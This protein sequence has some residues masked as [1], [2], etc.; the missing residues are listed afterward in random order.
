MRARTSWRDILACGNKTGT[1]PRSGVV[2]RHFVTSLLVSGLAV[3]TVL[4]V[5]SAAA[6]AD[7]MASRRLQ[8]SQMTPAEQQE[9]LRKQEQFAALPLEEQDRLRAL[10]AAI[11]TDAHADRLRQ[12]LKNYHEWLKTL[13]PAERAELAELAPEDRV[14]RI[15]QLQQRQRVARQEAQLAEVLSVKDMQAIIRWTENILWEHRDKVLEQLPPEWRKRLEKEDQQKQRRQLLLAASF[16]SRRSGLHPLAL[17]KPADIE[18][19]TARLSDPAKQE[20][21]KATDLAEQRKVVRGWIGASM[22]RLEPWQGRRKLPPPADQEL[23]DFFQNELRPPQRDRLLK[24]PNEQMRE[25]LRRMY[26][27]HERW[28]SPGRGF[29]KGPRPKGPRDRLGAEQPPKNVPV[30]KS[31]P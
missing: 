15:K 14:K 11:D 25:E 16:S 2:A 13:S 21:A 4:S 26:F 7:D 18:E 19:L 31:Q 24:M 10:Q 28:D 27:E 23:A 1:G 6:A 22:H 29:D 5:A 3:A 8:V 17:V 20:L 9:L 12:V 30:D